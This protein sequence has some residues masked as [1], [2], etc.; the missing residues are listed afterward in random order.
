MIAVSFVGPTHAAVISANPPSCS[1]RV[2]GYHRHVHQ[3]AEG[4]DQGGDGHLP[5]IDPQHV[6]HPE[7]YEDRD[8]DASPISSAERQSRAEERDDHHQDDCLAEAVHEQATFSVT[9]R[10]WSDVRAMIRCRATS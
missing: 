5:Q 6:S 10:G 3:Q 2:A 1:H 9:C 4:D 7:G 8:R